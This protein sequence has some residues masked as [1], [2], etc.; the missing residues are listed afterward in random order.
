MES[1][2]LIKTEVLTISGRKC[3]FSAISKLSN[4]TMK[5]YLT[6]IFGPS[7]CKKKHSL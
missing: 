5:P 2:P 1:F 6:M 7:S 4:P 3:V